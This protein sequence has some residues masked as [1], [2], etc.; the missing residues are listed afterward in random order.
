[1]SRGK[2]TAQVGVVLLA[3]L[4]IVGCMSLAGVPLP[5]SH[6]AQPPEPPRTV[7][8][9]RMPANPVAAQTTEIPV[10]PLPTIPT[11][12]SARPTAGQPMQNPPQPPAEM[13][14]PQPVVEVP[15][16]NAGPEAI[17]LLQRRASERFANVDSYIVRLTRRETVNGS[18]GE[19]EVLL[20]KF[21]KQPLSVHL[22]WLGPSGEGREALYVKGMYE[23]KLHTLLAAGDMPLAPAG[24]RLS[25]PLDSPLLE[26]RSR[27]RISDAGIGASID[28][29]GAILAAVDHGDP[30]L[31]QLAYLGPQQRK[32]YPQPVACVEHTLPAGAEK[33]LPRGGR[34]YYF[35]DP[36]TQ[37][38]M[39]I[40]TLDERGKQV[41][42]YFH[43]RL[44]ASVHLDAADFD[45]AKLWAK[46][47]AAGR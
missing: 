3:A 29:L 27:H 41:E 36:D 6:T 17:R 24:K 25:F 40:V 8:D 13:A 47:V 11:T 5:P 18:D 38:P 23:D 30:S 33:D 32:E 34:R 45:P 1:M 46:P 9:L 7:P 22:K 19:E 35:F 2:L 4:G 20:F 42:Y 12:E 39:L 16:A 14:R 37:L 10:V 28:R 43:D 44:Q 31:G 15:P 21:R 26:S